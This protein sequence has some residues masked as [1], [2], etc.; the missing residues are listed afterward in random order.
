MLISRSV[1]LKM[2]NGSEKKVVDE[3]KTHILF[4]IF[5]FSENR[6]VC[7]M[8][9]KNMVQA[10]RPQMKIRYVSC[11]LNAGCIRPQTQAEN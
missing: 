3:V 6:T 5:F 10:G 8:M 9:L 1:I 4:S 11:A 7:G 2:R